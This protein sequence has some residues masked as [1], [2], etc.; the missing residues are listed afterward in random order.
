MFFEKYTEKVW[1]RHP[2][3]ISAEWGA[4]RVKGLSILVLIKNLFVKSK[5]TSLIENFWYP[6]YGPGELWDVMANKIE[7]MCGVILKNHEVTKINIKN[8]KIESVECNKEIFNGDIFISSMPIKDLIESMNNVPKDINDVEIR[9]YKKDDIKL[10]DIIVFFVSRDLFH[11]GI[12][13]KMD[14]RYIYTIEGSSRRGS[15]GGVI[16]KGHDVTRRFYSIAYT[17]I[18]GMIKL[19]DCITE[20]K[21]KEELI[22]YSKDEFVDDVGR[23]LDML[24]DDSI[25]DILLF[26]PSLSLKSHNT[27]KLIIP[28]QKRLAALGYYKGQID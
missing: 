1:G 21:V 25:E 13:Y 10:G 8:N 27:N 12:V 7:E 24:C 20:D 2:S 17:R 28:V 16:Y 5:E 23:L 14:A 9:P 22:D 6:K 18:C 3:E 19:T 15:L 26:I 11:Y 4:Q